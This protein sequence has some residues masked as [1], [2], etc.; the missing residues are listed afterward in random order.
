MHEGW[1]AG[2]WADLAES[3]QREVLVEGA[4]QGGALA[5]LFLVAP[6]CALPFSLLDRSGAVVGYLALLTAATFATFLA[7]DK[8]ETAE[9]AGSLS[10]DAFLAPLVGG[11]VPPGSHLALYHF[12]RGLIR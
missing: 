1:L 8:V 5:R 6:E 9:V 4:V 10:V 3:F 2:R 11:S 7:S 12:K